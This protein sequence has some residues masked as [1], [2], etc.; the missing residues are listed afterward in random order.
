MYLSVI[1]QGMGHY[2]GKKMNRQEKSQSLPNNF[3]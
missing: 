2:L 1:F 3:A